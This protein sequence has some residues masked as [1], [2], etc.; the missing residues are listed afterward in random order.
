M[1]AV[2]KEYFV[3]L[4]R[5]FYPNLC[6]GC[7]E[8][9]VK[10]EK[11]LCIHCR[12]DLPFTNFE[13]IQDNPVEKVFYGRVPLQFATSLLY[14][15]KCEKTQQILHNI[16]YNGKREL[17]V[18]M[19]RLLGERLQKIADLSDITCIIPV[20]L[21]PQK[22]HI[23]GYN[24]SALF[25][26]GVNE[27]LKC[28][29][30]EKVIKRDIFTETQTKKG[31]VE[32]WENVAHAFKVQRPNLL[33]HQH[34]LLVDDVLTTGATLEACAVALLSAGNCKVSIATIAFAKN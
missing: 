16:K 11:H 29:L 32:R 6:G 2:A 33:H 1:L 26:E 8:P 12:L 4:Y 19:G 23:R 3:D 27:I 31:R 13:K 17:A 20:P 18:F 22:E 34:I 14:F 15:S 28:K 7:D 25:A 30:L 5:L 9:L 21:H 24:Q 10:S